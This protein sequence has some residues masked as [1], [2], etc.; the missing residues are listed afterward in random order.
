MS[1]TIMYRPTK[2]GETLPVMAPQ[3]FIASMELVCNGAS[4]PWM[5]NRASLPTLRGMAAVFDPFS[6]EKE[7]NPYL[8][9]IEEIERRGSI[10]VEVEY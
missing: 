3:R 5:F 6:L 4:A 1:A 2:P 9:L 8:I 7:K 10:V